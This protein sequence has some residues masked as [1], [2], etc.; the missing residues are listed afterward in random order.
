MSLQKEFLQNI[1]SQLPQGISFVDELAELFNVSNDSAYRRLRGETSMTFEEMALLCHKYNL[2]IDEFL[3]G[4]NTGKV[5]FKFKS[6]DESGYNFHEHF[7]SLL[8]VLSAYE[9]SPNAHMIYAANEARFSMFQV[10]EVAAFKMYY[11]MK[12]TLGFEK[13]QNQNFSPASIIKEYGSEIDLVVKKYVQIPTIEVFN[14]NYLDSTINQVKYYYDSGYFEN[15]DQALELANKLKDLLNHHK[16]EAELGYKFIHGKD[17]NGAEGNLQSFYNEVAQ[18]ENV[19][20]AK[21]GDKYFCYLIVNTI[22]FMLTSDQIFAKE[23]YDYLVN[24]KNKS[25]KI[26]VESERER[27]KFFQK[28]GRKIDALV[29]YLEM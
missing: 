8:T 27:N 12:T 13:Y 23:S 25:T 7:K 17:E 21:F 3:S 6:M 2:S 22:N 14:D 18:S 28:I 15:V 16:R 20:T 10:P 26:S 9:T 4:K 29:T 1:K 24:L 11:W 5:T 19:V